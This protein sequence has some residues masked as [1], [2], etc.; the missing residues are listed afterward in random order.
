M[1]DVERTAFLEGCELVHEL[2][3]QGCPPHIIK[4]VVT[5]RM[6][7]YDK[8]SAEEFKDGATEALMSKRMVS[9]A[10]RK[11]E[12]ALNRKGK[13]VSTIRRRG[14]VYRISPQGEVVDQTNSDEGE[15]TAVSTSSASI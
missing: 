9:S 13:K 4:A 2:A 7:S 14:H 15:L 8:P 5:E 12:R 6:L 3:D 10:K 11:K 1:T